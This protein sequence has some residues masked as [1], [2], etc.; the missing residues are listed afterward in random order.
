MTKVSPF[1][2]LLFVCDMLDPGELQDRNPRAGAHN[3]SGSESFPPPGFYFFYFSA[4][5]EG[6]PVRPVYNA[7]VTL[8]RDGLWTD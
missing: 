3:Q 5:F 1:F 6:T 7:P 4:V 2:F 8:N